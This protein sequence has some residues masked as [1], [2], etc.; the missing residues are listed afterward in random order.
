MLRSSREDDAVAAAAAQAPA[1]LAAGLA[2]RARD[3]D[4]H[5]RAAVLQRLAEIAPDT[6]LPAEALAEALAS[7]EPRLR[8]VALRLLVS[9]RDADPSARRARR[10]RIPRFAPREAA[11]SAALAAHGEAGVRAAQAYLR[12]GRERAVRAAL[13]VVAR[14]DA[15]SRRE[16]LRRELLHHARELWACEL[17]QPLLPAAAGSAPTFLRLA[18][19]DEAARHRRLAFRIL[20]LDGNPRAIR[21]VERAL[22]FGTRARARGRAR[23][24]LESRRPRGR[25]AAGAALRGRARRRAVAAAAARVHVPPERRCAA[26]GARGAR[27]ACGSAPRAAALDPSLGHNAVGVATMERLLA[28]RKVP[29]FESLTLDQLDAVDQLA[30]ER[31][32]GPAR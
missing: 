28:L 18:W 8:S 27:R 31:D 26:G 9:R 13:E 1:A 6:A 10:S 15:P 11:R 14:A 12:D 25:A 17:V 23:G 24:A 4:P 21:N 30:E 20:G 5:V 19:A 16:L 29:L 3:A 2:A 22:R 32:F 7:P